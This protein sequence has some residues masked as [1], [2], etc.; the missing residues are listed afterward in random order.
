[1]SLNSEGI[2]D[3]MDLVLL[4]EDLLAILACIC[5][6]LK[7][8]FVWV[9]QKELSRFVQYHSVL[10]NIMIKTIIEHHFEWKE[11]W[12]FRSCYH[13]NFQMVD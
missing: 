13:C 1:M 7:I 10:T 6:I 4:K 12:N 2:S 3:K 5:I 11:C 9:L 8:S